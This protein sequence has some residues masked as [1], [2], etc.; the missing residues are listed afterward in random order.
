M[1]VMN[2]FAGSNGDV[3]TESRL[4]DTEGGS[5]WDGRRERHGNSHDTRWTLDSRWASAVRLRELKRGGRWEGGSRGR[6]H[7][8]TYGRSMW[9]V[10]GNQHG[11]V[12]ILRLKIKIK[13]IK[14]KFLKR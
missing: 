1:V 5:G 8:L 13:K 4:M 6:G 2:L 10:G 12:I 7:T 14:K 9:M 3:D 11:I